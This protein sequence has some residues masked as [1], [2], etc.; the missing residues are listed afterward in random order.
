M[1]KKNPGDRKAPGST[2]SLSPGEVI[3]SEWSILAP[4]DLA[5]PESG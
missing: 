4:I 3:M 1:G 5:L 2:T